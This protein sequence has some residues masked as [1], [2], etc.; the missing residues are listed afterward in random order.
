[1]SPL[2]YTLVFVPLAIV[3]ELLHASPVLI[4]AM[5]SLG[6]IPLASLIGEATEELAAPTGPRL[7]GLPNATLGNAAALIITVFAIRAGL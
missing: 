4:F 5:A 3:A 2:Y 6:V 7:G 1:M